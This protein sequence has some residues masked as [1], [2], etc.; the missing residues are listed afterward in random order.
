M[1]HAPDGGIRA[2]AH[3]FSMNGTAEAQGLQYGD[4]IDG[5]G[6][7]DRKTLAPQ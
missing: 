5:W 7:Q 2:T 6:C 3:R 4:R 1:G